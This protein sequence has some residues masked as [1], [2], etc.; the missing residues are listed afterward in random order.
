VYGIIPAKVV[1]LHPD[2][3]MVLSTLWDAQ[4]RR[5]TKD[6]PLLPPTNAAVEAA[7]TKS[8]AG[9]TDALLASGVPRVV[10]VE[11][12]PP[13]PSLTGGDDQQSQPARHSV[14]RHVVATIAFSRPAVRIVDLAAWVKAQPLGRDRGARPDGVHWTGEASLQIANGFLG[15]A[16]V[17]AALS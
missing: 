15:A 11:S 9:F 12:P 1:E 14:L 2:V 7:I 6:G 5:L 17:R 4:D 8:L 13:L 16:L 10:W 3:V